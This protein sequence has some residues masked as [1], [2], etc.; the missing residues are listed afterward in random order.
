MYSSGVLFM[1]WREGYVGIYFLGCEA[2]REMN[3]KINLAWGHNSHENTY[4]I[5][6]LTWLNESTNDDK[7]N[8]AHA[9]L[10]LTLP[11]VYEHPPSP[12]LTFYIL[13]M[14][15][16]SIANDSITT[17]RD[18]KCLTRAC[19]NWYLTHYIWILFTAILT[20]G[21]LPWTTDRAYVICL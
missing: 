6:F 2:S 8:D 11:K 10:T 15:S 3:T 17:L 14:K 19:E 1:C 20:A 5:I 13:L 4:I 16:Q 7:N 21:R 18:A 12:C 9:S